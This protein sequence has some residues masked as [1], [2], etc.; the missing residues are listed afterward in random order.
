MFLLSFHFSVSI[1]VA[2]TTFEV[3]KDF[4]DATNGV[5]WTSSI[6][7]LT[8]NSF[9]MWHGITTDSTGYV[10]KLQLDENNLEGR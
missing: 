5:N 4:F 3:L 1:E 7:W 8:N 9:N 2:S 10:T 6:N